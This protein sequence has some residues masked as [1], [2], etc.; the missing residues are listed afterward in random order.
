M[1]E[2]GYSQSPAFKS[3]NRVLAIL[4]FLAAGWTL[5]GT[6]FNLSRLE[7]LE[8][9]FRGVK[10]QLPGLAILSLQHWMAFDVVLVVIAGTCGYATFRVPDR[11][12]TVFLNV[13]GIVLPLL[14]WVLQTICLY[15]GTSAM[16][17]VYYSGR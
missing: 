7:R 16:V 5:M 9:I 14:W 4:V 3:V 1:S 8:G 10:V 13:A 6:H 17:D 2:D 11:R 12:K 15:A